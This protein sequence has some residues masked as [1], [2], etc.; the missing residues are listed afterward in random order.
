LHSK[1]IAYVPSVAV[2]GI[3]IHPDIDGKRSRWIAKILE[4]DLEINPTK[5]V[6]GQGLAKLLDESNCK[7]LGI[8]FI[9]AYS[10]S[11][12]AELSNKISQDGLPLAKCTC[13]RDIM[14]FLL[15]LKLPD[16]IGKSKARDLKL[17]AVRYC[18]IDQ[19]LHWRDPLGVIIR[20]LYP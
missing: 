2:K 20:C 9:N 11:Q 4:F 7:A 16:G 17:K 19:V 13:Y 15:E 1:I 8:S 18:I 5:L 12:Q 10:E 3:L 6:K 14:Y